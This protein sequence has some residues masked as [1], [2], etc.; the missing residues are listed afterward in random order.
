MINSTTFFKFKNIFWR[1]NLQFK[2][3]LN[4]NVP[5]IY[6]LPNKYNKLPNKVT[7]M[8]IW[9]LFWNPLYNCFQES[10]IIF[11]TNTW[12]NSNLQYHIHCVKRVQMRSFFWSVFSRVRTEYGEILRISPY[13]VRMRENTDQKKLRIWTH[14]TQWFPSFLELVIT[15]QR[16]ASYYYDSRYC[17]SYELLLAYQLQV[18]I[19]LKSYDIYIRVT[20]CH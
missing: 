11:W 6:W 9:Q 12:A 7:K 8:D 10:H 2:K 19:Y 1:M 5:S 17:T 16:A 4:K 3:L 18:T 13:S 20:I 14:F 15:N